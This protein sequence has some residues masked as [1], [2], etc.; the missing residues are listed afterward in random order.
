MSISLQ[1]ISRQYLL[2]DGTAVQA[3]Q[4]VS[5]TLPEASFHV[6]IGKSGCGKTTLLRILAGL[7]QPDRG[8]ITMAAPRIGVMFQTPRLLPWR[9]VWENICLWEAGADGSR[10]LA[11]H[12]LEAFGLS[13]F[14]D[15]YPQQ[16]S[17][18]MAQRAALA[19]TLSYEPSLLLMDEPF[20]ALDY[21]TRQQLQDELLTQFAS[22]PLTVLFITHDIAEAARLG[23]HI[24]VMKQGR[25]AGQ[26]DNP[27][28]YPRPALE[29][30]FRLEK[31]LLRLL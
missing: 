7:E 25:I 27:A 31:Q 10:E 4:D 23:Q 24:L 5:L 8:Q 19:R 12:Y 21:F 2:P 18:G 22:Q 29:D 6:L 16:L 11:E 26:V 14:R 17:G 28:P 1:G 20:A 9:T 15:A 3:L 13:R 30:R